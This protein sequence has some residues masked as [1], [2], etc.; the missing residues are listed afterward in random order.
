MEERTERKRKVSEFLNSL[1]TA[2]RGGERDWGGRKESRERRG[3]RERG[4][5]IQGRGMKTRDVCIM[6]ACA[7]RFDAP[8]DGV[9]C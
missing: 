9:H 4:A 2:R 1:H 6:Y 3:S 7:A 8:T 5:R